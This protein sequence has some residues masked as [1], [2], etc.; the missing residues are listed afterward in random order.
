MTLGFLALLWI[1]AFPVEVTVS[2]RDVYMAL[3]SSSV[4][5]LVGLNANQTA[6]LRDF[7]ESVHR[8][9]IVRI[10]PDT[11]VR[12]LDY[13][14][15]TPSGLVRPFPISSPRPDV[16]AVAKVKVLDGPHAG[17]AG[18]VLDGDLRFRAPPLP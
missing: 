6:A 5:V 15:V 7:E 10:A 8:G 17:I 4:R 13:K 18:W 3:D 12:R 11:R 14:I 1:Y 9:Q 16:F 2:E